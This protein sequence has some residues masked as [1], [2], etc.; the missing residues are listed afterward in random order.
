MEKQPACAAPMSSSGL[1]PSPFSNR[2]TK[3]YAPSQAPLPMRIVP[4]PSLSVPFQTAA[5]LRT[6]MDSP[7]VVLRT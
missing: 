7:S 6:A 2:E 1:V 5:A 3:E 4:S